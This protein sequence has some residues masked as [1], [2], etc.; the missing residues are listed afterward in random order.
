MLAALDKDAFIRTKIDRP[1]CRNLWIVDWV[2]RTQHTARMRQFH[3]ARLAPKI[4][5]NENMLLSS[6]RSYM[7]IS[8][9]SSPDGL[10][11]PWRKISYCERNRSSRRYRQ[12]RIRLV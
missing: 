12:K 3:R 11:V 5:R 6:Q 1:V 2:R 10:Y 8:T 9:S 7:K 4:E